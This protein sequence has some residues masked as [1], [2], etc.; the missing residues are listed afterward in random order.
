MRWLRRIALLLVALLA[1]A[2]IAAYLA[3][4]GSLPRLDGDAALPG[5]SAPATLS[6]DALG[7][8][9]VDA[10]GRADAARALGWVHAQE[11]YFE[12]DLLRRTAAG[13]LSGLFGSIALDN[14]KRHRV[15]RLRARAQAQ[16][17]SL[18][19]NEQALL[20]AY[21]DGANAGL[22]A[23]G[24]RP[25]AYLPLR[26]RPQPWRAEDSL[27]VGYAMYFDLQ[28]GDGA[29]ELAL[30]RLRPHLPPALY[31]LLRHD[32]TRWDAPMAGNVR[33]DAVLP[34][35]AAVDLRRLPMPADAPRSG[36]IANDIMP[37][38]NNFAVAGALT[39]DGRAILA[40]DMHLGLR[41]PNIWFRAR[42]RYPDAAAPDA[43][44]EATGFTLP[45]LPAVIAGS[46]G[47]VAWGY[48]NGYVDVADWQRILPCGKSQSPG[49]TPTRVH[50]EHI[51][52]AGGK[53]V[54]FE[55]EESDWGP[56]LHRDE[57]GALALRWIAHAPDALNLHLGEM[58]RAGNVEQALAIAQQ[59]RMPAQNLLLADR[60]GRVAWRLTGALPQRAAGCDPAS[61]LQ[62]PS[63]APWPV[64]GSGAPRLLDPP[65]GRLWSANNRTADGA[66]LARVGDGG[67][68]LGARAR[69]IRDGLF[70]AP[71][72]D[73]QSLLAIQLDDRAL[74][75]Q[76]W[77]ALLREVAA[78]SGTP[79]L[80]ALSEAAAAPMPR[81]SADSVA[82]RVVRAWRLAVSERLASGLLAP[83][84][85]ALGDAFRMP[86]LQ[87]FEGVA[88]PLVTRRP[89]HLLPRRFA[90]WDAL[91]EDA[92]VQVRDELSQAGPLA[93]R[94]WGE[95]NTSAICHPL[96]NALPLGRHW[97]CMPAQALPGDA[98]MPRVQAPGFGASERMVVAPGHEE[99][100]IAHMP[101]GQSGHPLSPYWGAGHDDW[102]AGRASPFL[103][104]KT[105]HRL[106]LQPERV[107]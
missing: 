15:H 89:P 82:Y 1:L 17:R 40:N 92:A 64:A 67:Y 47:H 95:R 74:F 90:S 77:Q 24:V 96:A 56:I 76:P 45:G 51:A 93:A 80:R 8:L 5:L 106:R 30:L 11:R 3:M 16:L 98:S 32:G 97:L 81:A 86:A 18:P 73:E 91:F 62:A 28:G 105:R 70:I 87:Q 6:R 33:G 99:R 52:V 59:V 20:A 36:G 54:P 29:D 61:L 2:A 78:Q 101:G 10:S 43:L 60:F 103:P 37:G 100:A 85:A 63:C 71:R 13:E 9:T 39:D 27:L 22:A 104:G 42:L 7:V 107:R 25:W 58:T 46:N 31:A 49:C 44:V 83:A 48:T 4:R 84:Q 50:R 53:P 38:S 102:A 65:S 21:A 41:A 55:V 19:A 75:L 79:A 35:A 69:Q 88:W 14:D 34:D 66:A 12:M 72:L 26:Q 68:A 57:D 94:S 23:L